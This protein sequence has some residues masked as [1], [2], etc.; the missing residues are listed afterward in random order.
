MSKMIFKL[1][2]AQ[3]IPEVYELETLGFPKDEAADIGTLA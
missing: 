3:D 1:V 2:P